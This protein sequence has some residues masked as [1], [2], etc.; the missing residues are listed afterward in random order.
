MIRSPH[1]VAPGSSSASRRILLVSP[2]YPPC[3]EVGALRWEKITMFAERQG[4]GM[5]VITGA[6]SPRDRIDESR[7]LSLPAG[8]RVWTIPMP[9]LAVQ[10]LDRQLMAMVA[11]IRRRRALVEVA[12]S[13]AESPVTTMAAI[14]TSATATSAAPA[15]LRNVRAWSYFAAW[16]TWG[17]EVL[18]LAQDLGRESLPTVVASSG[19]PHMTHE[20]ARRVAVALDRPLV[21]DLRDPWFVDEAEPA[22]LAG[23]TWRRQTE[24]YEASACADARLIV[25]N[26]ESSAALMRERYPSFVNR[27]MTVMNGADDDVKKFAGE[28]SAT[29]DIVHAGSLYSGRD[30]RPLFRG[31]R[32]FLDTM[33]A[34]TALVRTIFIG[35]QQYD[36]APLDDLAREC[37]LTEH[38]SCQAPLPRR[39]ALQLSGDAAIN[40]VLPQDWSHSIPSKVFEYMQFSAWILALSEPSDAITQLLRDTSSPS[41]TPGDTDAI[42]TFIAERFSY[43]NTGRKATGK[44]SRAE[45]LNTDG[46]FDRERQV[47][48]LLRAIHD[49]V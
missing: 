45:P 36:G 46:R 44:G 12:S 23:T 4:W 20:A 11:P 6:A 3:A 25:V 13:A 32:R 27:V 16:N 39:Q 30:P 40:V 15:I 43:W 26:T 9:V 33:P 2:A 41:I 34:A 47:E 42:A 37:G 35:A 49:V 24:K 22:D 5:D 48:Q 19:P 18:A 8:T 28:G 7:L 38:F 14:G 10:R 17:D 31:V 29:F 1:Y 21:I